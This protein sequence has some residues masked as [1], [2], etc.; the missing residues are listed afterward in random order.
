MNSVDDIKREGTRC[1][2]RVFWKDHKKLIKAAEELAKKK[3]LV[4]LSI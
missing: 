4:E 1:Y 2:N 3:F